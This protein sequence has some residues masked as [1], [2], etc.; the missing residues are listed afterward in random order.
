MRAI[1]GSNA[2]VPARAELYSEVSEVCMQF[3]KKV[4]VTFSD[5]RAFDCCQLE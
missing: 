2:S 1:C 5:F 3:L 4:Q